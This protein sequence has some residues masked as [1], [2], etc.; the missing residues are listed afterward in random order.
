MEKGVP[1]CLACADLDHLVFLAKGDAA[2]TR[3]AGKY[4]TLRAVVRR[5]SR[6]RKKYERQ[7]TLVEE[8]ALI[9][10]EEECAKDADSRER[11]R[12]RAAERRDEV[13]EAHV[14]R[15]AARIRELFPDC[16]RSAA[17]DPG[18]MH[19]AGTQAA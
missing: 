10:A 12:E 17:S 4:S 9:R 5:F 11:A 1:L 18:D 14:E 16:P 13:D 6:A 19:A 2:L 3:R 15:F 8:A 7:G